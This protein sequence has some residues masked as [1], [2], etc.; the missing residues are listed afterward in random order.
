MKETRTHTHT[1]TRVRSKIDKNEKLTRA[2]ENIFLKKY[3]GP[4]FVK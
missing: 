3:L 1:H 2:R 4:P